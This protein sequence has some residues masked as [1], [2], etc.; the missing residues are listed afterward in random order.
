[1]LQYLNRFISISSPAKCLPMRVRRLLLAQGSEF[2]V[3]L[4]KLASFRVSEKL[5][6]FLWKLNLHLHWEKSGATMLIFEYY[7]QNLCF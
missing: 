6:S 7:N 1:M 3:D 4:Y 2:S 5:P